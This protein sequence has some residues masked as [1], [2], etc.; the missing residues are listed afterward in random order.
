MADQ[1]EIFLEM[2]TKHTRSPHIVLLD[3][4]R[5]VKRKLVRAFQVMDSLITLKNLVS[6]SMLPKLIPG[7][8]SR[9]TEDFSR[10][11]DGGF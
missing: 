6:G 8:C 9:S 2:R 10:Y 1:Y 4:V 5:N 11:G 3:H 7:I